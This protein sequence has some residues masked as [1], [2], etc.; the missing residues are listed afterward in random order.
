MAIIL[1][2][3]KPIANCK[4]NPPHF[5]TDIEGC[6]VPVIIGLDGVPDKWADGT[7]GL[8][9]AQAQ[10]AYDNESAYCPVCGTEVDWD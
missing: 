9:P 7:V 5:L 8:T 6:E 2:L 3:I 10:E 4:C 1:G